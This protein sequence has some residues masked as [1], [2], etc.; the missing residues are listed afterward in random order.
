LLFAH[1]LRLP[2]AEGKMPGV[3]EAIHQGAQVFLRYEYALLALFV[4]VLATILY[5]TLA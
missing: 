2:A 1:V 5:F 4:S 3:A